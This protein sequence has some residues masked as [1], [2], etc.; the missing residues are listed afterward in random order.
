MRTSFILAFSMATFCGGAAFAQSVNASYPATVVS[1]M[2]DLGYSTNL[3]EDSY[4]DPIIY[5]DIPGKSYQVLFYGCSE[6]IDCKDLQ[7]RAIYENQ[8]NTSSS[9]PATY[10]ADRMV[11][12]I[13]VSAEYGTTLEHTIIGVDGLSRSSFN[14][15]IEKW[16]AAIDFYNNMSN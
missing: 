5:A 1:A 9:I 11:G 15:T 8:T 14:R 6:N 13:Y 16:T 12:K 7:L 4:G 10:N 3:T 2:Q